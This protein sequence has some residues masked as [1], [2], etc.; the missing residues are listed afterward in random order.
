[1]KQF[2]NWRYIVA[3]N[4]RH[5]TPA[6][7]RAMLRRVRVGERTVRSLTGGFA[8]AR[9]TEFVIDKLEEKAK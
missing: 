5:M 8:G 9:L 3:A 6:Q 4:V 1:M 7:A 2:H